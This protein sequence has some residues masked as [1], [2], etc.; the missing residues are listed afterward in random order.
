MIRRRLSGAAPSRRSARA[1]VDEGNAANAVKWEGGGRKRFARWAQREFLPEFE[2]A[3]HMA[4]NTLAGEVFGESVFDAFLQMLVT[5]K[6]ASNL[7]AHFGYPAPGSKDD[8]LVSMWGQTMANLRFRHPDR[9]GRLT[10]PTAA[11][12]HDYVVLKGIAETLGSY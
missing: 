4:T 10:T 9:R 6:E 2:K 8:A 12:E 5:S 7:S 11:Y 1:R 3:L